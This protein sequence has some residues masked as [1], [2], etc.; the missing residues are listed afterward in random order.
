MYQNTLWLIIWR[1]QPLHKGHI[2]L[3]E[4]SLG[5]N[6]ATLVLIG[7]VNKNDEKNPYSFKE[8]KDF[9]LWEFTKEKLSI[10]SLPDF[11]KDTDWIHHI[12][13]HIPEQITNCNIYCGDKSNDY[14]VQVL[15][16]LRSTLPFT[17]NII[18]ID[19]KIFPV[20]GTWVRKYLEQN[21]ILKLRSVLWKETL[22][23]IK[24]NT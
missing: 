21:D 14:A 15:E 2:K 19:R 23:N 12:L 20:S 5:E 18:E 1:F 3:I 6:P 4:T 10:A 16:K 22:K 17:L 9:I 13:L 24:K 7:S 11:Q 8:R